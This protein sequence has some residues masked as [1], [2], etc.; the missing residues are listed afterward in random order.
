MQEQM[1]LL[2]VKQKKALSEDVQ[3][4]AFSLNLKSPFG[5]DFD[6]GLLF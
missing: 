2:Y 4:H 1:C 3:T 5:Q 6:S